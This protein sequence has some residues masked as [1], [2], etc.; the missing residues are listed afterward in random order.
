[1]PKWRVKEDLLGLSG[2]IVP[3]SFSDDGSP[4]SINTRFRNLVSATVIFSRETQKPRLVLSHF[5]TLMGDEDSFEVSFRIANE[6]P[7][8]WEELEDLV[9]GKVRTKMESIISEITEAIKPLS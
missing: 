7:N 5:S 3:L 2:E 1:M 8:T 4:S 6:I 9:V